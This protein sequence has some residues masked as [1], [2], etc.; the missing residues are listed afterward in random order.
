MVLRHGRRVVCTS[1]SRRPD[2][3]CVGPSV[4]LKR[5]KTTADHDTPVLSGLLVLDACLQSRCPRQ[6][7]RWPRRY[8]GGGK[9]EASSHCWFGTRVHRAAHD[10]AAPPAAPPPAFA[11][12]A[13]PL[14][15]SCLRRGGAHLCLQARVLARSV[16]LTGPRARCCLSRGVAGAS[17]VF[18]SLFG[19]LSVTASPPGR[20]LPHHSHGLEAVRPRRATTGKMA[21]L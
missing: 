8:A 15:P 4:T 5:G 7:I 9:C 2:A 13:P 1:T 14:K 21:F 16:S 12:G 11:F 10:A 20:P 18:V 3:S 6:A 19:H 17:S